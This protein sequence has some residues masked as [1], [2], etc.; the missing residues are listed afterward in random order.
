MTPHTPQTLGS[1]PGHPGRSSTA[2]S[3]AGF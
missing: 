3:R 2:V 1:A